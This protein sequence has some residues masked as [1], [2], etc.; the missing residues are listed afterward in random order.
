MARQGTIRL[1]FLYNG[2]ET[3]GMIDETSYKVWLYE[4]GVS[5]DV[6]YNSVFYD[7][8]YAFFRYCMDEGISEDSIVELVRYMVEHGINDSRDI[9]SDMWDSFMEETGND[10]DDVRGLLENAADMVSIP[11]LMGFL[12]RY[13][14]IVLM[15]GGIDECLKEV[16]IA[17]MALG[18][19]Y[20]VY[21]EYTY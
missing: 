21:S 7:K 15:G 16:E 20:D 19:N 18:K 12:E 6:I 17:L 1:F 13:S 4:L 9:D 2:A 10:M 3:L 8:G 11:D 5:E 14:G